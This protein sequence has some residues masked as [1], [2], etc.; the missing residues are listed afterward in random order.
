MMAV[1]LVQQGSEKVQQGSGEAGGCCGFCERRPFCQWRG[2]ALCSRDES[3]TSRK[4]MGQ[5]GGNAD[6]SLSSW[7]YLRVGPTI[8]SLWCHLKV[9]LYIP[10]IPIYLIAQ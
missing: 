6:E 7:Q 3:E 9:V 10:Y 5:F 8:N 2:C 1:R 4:S